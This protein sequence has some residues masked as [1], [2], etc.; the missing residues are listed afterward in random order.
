MNNHNTTPSPQSP[1]SAPSS[2]LV[3]VLA[4]L[5]VTALLVGAGFAAN[6]YVGGD[7]ELDKLGLLADTTLGEGQVPD[8]ELISLVPEGI[9]QDPVEQESSET[10][11]SLAEAARTSPDGEV[12]GEVTIDLPGDTDLDLGDVDI[13]VIVD[14]SGEV[15]GIDNGFAV[16]D[17]PLS[18]ALKDA[19]M[20]S[21]LPARVGMGTGAELAHLKAHL[22]DDHDYLYFEFGSQDFDLHLDLGDEFNGAD[23]LPQRISMNTDTGSTIFVAD[24]NAD[25]F[26][27]SVPC[28]AMIG[29]STPKKARPDKKREN[30]LAKSEA[31]IPGLSVDLTNVDPGGCGIGWST[32][33]NI[34]F[35]PLMEE[36]LSEIPQDFTSHIVIDG[37][38]PVHPLFTVDGE[39]FIRFD[40]DGMRTWSNAE[41]QAELAY[42]RGA[43]DVSI[44]TAI[45]TIGFLTISPISTE[46]DGGIEVR[47]AV[48]ADAGTDLAGGVPPA[49][50]EELLP[51]SG[52]L[53]L[54]GVLHYKGLGLTDDS[55]VEINGEMAMSSNNVVHNLTS[56][57]SED[58]FHATGRI[59]VDSDGI[60][61]TATAEQSPFP[62][63]DLNGTATLDIGIPFDSLEDS[64]LQFTGSANFGETDI[65]AEA[66]I[67]LDN[68][69]LLVTGDIELVDYGYV[70]VLGR[71]GPGEVTLHG[72]AEVV[73]PI[74]DLDQLADRVLS[75]MTNQEQI[76]SLDRA[77][78]RRVNELSAAS[79]REEAKLRTTI[80]A[81]RL[82]YAEVQKA[83][84]NIRINNEKIAGVD[85]R[86]KAEKDRHAALS[87]GQRIIDATPHGIKLAALETERAAYV[88]ANKT[89]AAYR[90]TSNALLSSTA[91]ATIAAVAW[92]DELNDLVT[93]QAEAYWGNLTTAIANTLLLGVDSILDAFLI[94]G[95][96]VGMVDI[97][98]GTEA[99]AGAGNLEWCRDGECSGATGVDVSFSPAFS[100][101][102]TVLGLNNCL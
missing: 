19:F 34:P 72:E 26:Y 52:E 8:A 15:I 87:F 56:P 27:F 57:D 24:M 83:N 46:M 32:G 70:E 85:R 90:D 95:S 81:F 37:T 92:D 14:E 22:I 12:T 99:L 84:D 47:L 10:S 9:E 64:F 79:P 39:S 35:T 59:R 43:V 3:I 74:G 28:N 94:D 50:L 45:G 38:I 29:Q 71:I 75:D 11:R 1:Q 86:I 77:I 48:T 16:V 60:V 65:G 68:D 33:G 62:E 73:V 51:V 63:V 82:A 30:S 25:Y 7:V 31:D 101:C 55:F 67:R 98:V 88:A 6:Y 78:D 61:A 40:P 42:A 20:D 4:T 36:R 5:I 18:G 91:Q 66:L 97:T 100:V 21:T 17:L 80:A 96:L 23:N 102:G 69:G 13:D 93:M 54:D 89:N 76:A 53:E 41:M 49:L 44:P 2:K 58:V